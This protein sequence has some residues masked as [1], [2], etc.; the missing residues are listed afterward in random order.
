MYMIIKLTMLFIFNVIVAQNTFWTFLFSYI[1][2]KVLRRVYQIMYFS[3]N[4]SKEK[5]GH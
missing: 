1:F 2:V 3:C 5:P 4:I